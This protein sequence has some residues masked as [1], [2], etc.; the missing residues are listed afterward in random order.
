M[1]TGSA[2]P[3]SGKACCVTG[4][5]KVATTADLSESYLKWAG[6]NGIPK[7]EW[8]NPTAFG[9]A[10]TKRGYLKDGTGKKRSGIGLR[11][12]EAQTPF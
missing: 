2:T 4:D 11:A 10:L 8:L 5:G 12:E 3:Q 1:A 9:R 6:E 7:Y